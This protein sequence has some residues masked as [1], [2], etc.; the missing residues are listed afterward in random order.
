MSAY[1][2]ASVSPFEDSDNSAGDD[3]FPFLS[4]DADAHHEKLIQ[5]ARAEERQRRLLLGA[6]CI[7]TGLLLL[8]LL[9][10]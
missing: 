4:A 6:V 9:R 8:M 5:R 3:R 7:M 10:N 2:L 1:P